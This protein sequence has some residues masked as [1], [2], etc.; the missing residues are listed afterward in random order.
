MKRI[1][2]DA[3]HLLRP[4]RGIPLY[5]ARLCHHL[6][7]LDSKNRYY[8]FINR[9]FEHNAPPAEYEPRLEALQSRHDN[10]TVINRD[11]DAEIAWEQFELPRMVR[12]HR[13]DLLHMPGNR[14]CFRPGVPVVV[15]VHDIMEWIYLDTA[16]VAGVIGS[17]QGLK[18]KAYALRILAYQWANYRFG[19]RRANRVVTVSWHSAGDIVKHLGIPPDR[20]V[21]IHHGL[22]DIF[23][24][25]KSGTGEPFLPLERRRHVLMLGGDSEQKNPQGAIAA[26]ARVPRDVRK[27]FP[28]KVVGFCGDH[29][30]PLIEAIERHRLRGEVSVKGWVSEQELIEGLQE[31][32][33]FIYPSR[34]EGFGFPPLH[35]MACATPVASTTAASIP[36]VMGGAGIRYDPDD[37][38]ALA[39]GM[40][41]LLTDAGMWRD[42]VSMGLARSRS[43][44]W[45]RSAE[46]H[47][48]VYREVLQYG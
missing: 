43:F 46:A 19:F 7:S 3:R 42:Q 47:L 30:S 41:G 25:G 29:S 45:Q 40:T 31:A 44:D 22:D 37:H 17:K 33:L 39:A 1:A 28:L 14:I 38:A 16:R 36:E 4:L 24:P 26:W 23:A 5:V 15:T 9:G 20:V 8:L 10:L 12:E 32:A 6:P 35:A 34:Y 27:R 13:I 48:K 11:D 21:P 2:I 18:M